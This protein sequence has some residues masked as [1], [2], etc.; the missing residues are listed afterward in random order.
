MSIQV[1]NNA[2]IDW[3]SLLNKLDAASKAASAQGA[4]GVTAGSNV[5]ITATVDGVQK[6]VTF[7]VPDDLDLPA[8]VDQAGIDSL[9]AKLAGDQSLGLTESDVK[10]VH[11]A[12]TR[13]LSAAAPSLTATASTGG[14]KSVMF[15][16]Y[17]LMALLVEVGQKQRDSAREL[18]TAQNA[19]IQKSIQDTADLQKAAALTG[20]I[21][22]AICCAIQVIVSVGM[23]AKQGGAFKK[24]VNSL[25]TSGVSSAK[26]NLSMMEAADSPKAAKAQLTKVESAIGGKQV[27]GSQHRTVA[28]DV[29]AGF[30]ESEKAEATYKS[31]QTK[32]SLDAAKLARLSD[33]TQ[34]LKPGDVPADSNM[35]K[36]QAE[37]AKFDQDPKTQRLA[38]LEANPK[39]SVAESREMLELQQGRPSRA[40]LVKKVD[41]G[42]AELAEKAKA[43]IPKDGDKIEASRVAYREAVKSDL[44]RYENEY[45]SAL[46]ERSLAE[47]PTKAQSAALD[48]KVELAANKLQYARALANQKLA[49]PGVSMPK[50]RALDIRVA[51][52]QVMAA[53]QG[54]HLDTSY[55]KATH[56][57]QVGE[58]K[59][60]LVTAIGNATQSFIS[61]ISNY[62]QAEAKEKEAVEA[63]EKDELEQTK[64]LFNQAQDL[65]DAVVQL[66]QAVSSAESQ[67]MRDAIQA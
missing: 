40:E 7:P 44:A 1:N 25:E 45:Q 29:K 22:G 38:E 10:A 47:N 41:A 48:A 54:R 30:S 46:S 24:Q 58:A 67:S 34:P 19:Q 27:P 31:A 17:K 35:A 28:A 62:I 4:G 32:A 60:G 59:L 11:S 14:S 49:E 12:L 61:G 3:S 50:E 23:L 36:A 16:L 13:T 5:T 18:R 65:V 37:L 51:S 26:Q 53:E 6:T 20:M 52:D 43:Q 64:D 56:A 15:D 55:L 33:P 8:Q 2:S 57:L 9:C 66:M 63:K 39:R 21:A 42:R